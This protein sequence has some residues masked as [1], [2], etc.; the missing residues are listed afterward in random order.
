MLGSDG[1]RFRRVVLGAVQNFRDIGGYATR[2]GERT[3]WGQVFRSDSLHKLTD[4]EITIFESLGV[5]TVCD[6]RRDDERAENPQG[7][8]TV[9]LPLP[10]QRVTDSDIAGLRSRHDGEQWLFED[11]IGMLANGGPV[12]GRL[13]SLLAATSDPVVVHCMSGK[14]R[15]GLVTALLLTLLEVDRETVLDD[16][17]L[18]SAYFGVD[19]ISGVVELFVSWGIARPAAEAMLSTPRWAMSDALAM[20]DN[21]YG[22]IARFLRFRASLDESVLRELRYRLIE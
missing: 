16:Y 14:D 19:H 7:L 20:L 15:T 6:L 11:Y 4:D 17:E 5:R 9:H 13:F 2:S 1:E 8:P 22:G 10:S 3:R 21:G 12:I 18:T